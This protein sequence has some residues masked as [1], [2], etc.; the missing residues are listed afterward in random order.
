MQEDI[1]DVV[2]ENDSVI[3][4]KPRSTVHAEGL[5]H[6]AIHV[7]IFNEDD[8][9]FIQKRSQNKDTWPGA[10]D[11]S[12]SG[13]VDSGEDYD[14]AALRELQEELSWQPEKE[15]DFLFKLDPCEAT[16][17][18]FVKVYQTRG[19]G[20][21]RLNPE[22]IDLGEWADVPNLL[23]RVEYTPYKF[24]SAF[25]LILQR[26]NDQALLPIKD[27]PDFQ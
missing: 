1:F 18:E 12:C 27:S 2:D 15:L 20:P 23:K 19:D 11:S 16:G 6:R 26:M 24:S 9:V 8:E 10:W 21:F 7:L 3:G 25:A 22:E 14:A 4:S 13:H 17:Q 5:M